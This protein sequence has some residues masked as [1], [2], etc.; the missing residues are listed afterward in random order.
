MAGGGG[1][2]TVTSDWFEPFIAGSSAVTAVKLF[3]FITSA[4]DW[5]VCRPWIFVAR[6]RALDRCTAICLQQTRAVFRVIT[7]SAAGPARA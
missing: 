1:G 4:L 6:V 7:W 2:E 5:Y 3:Q